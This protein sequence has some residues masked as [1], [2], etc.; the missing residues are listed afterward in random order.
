[1]CMDR[2]IVHHSAI[3][4]AS[5]DAGKSCADGADLAEAVYPLL[6]GGDNDLEMPSYHFVSV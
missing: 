3:R 1:M 4:G 6:E 5:P 2:T